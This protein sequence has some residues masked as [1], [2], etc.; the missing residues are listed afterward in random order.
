MSEALLNTAEAARFLRVSQAS[1]RRWSDAGLLPARRVGPRRERRFTKADL[2]TFM[3]PAAQAIARPRDS[4]QTEV[5]VGGTRVPVHSHVATFYSSDDG[6]LRLTIPFIREGLRLGQPCFL[7]AAGD[8]LGG[9]MHALREDE[10]IDVDAASRDGMFVT[11]DGPGDSV[12]AALAFWE[13][14]MSHALASGPTL[15]RVVGEMISE[16]G[17]FTSDAEMIRYEVA[18]NGIAKRFPTVT[19]C[20]YDARSF[21]G[22]VLFHALRAHPDLYHLGIASFLN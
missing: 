5:S 19:L 18:F 11:A 4:I 15:M 6:R 1:I 16:R 14:S 10:G 8:V 21:S 17:V 20:Q 13:R 7:A 9:Y 3:T 12:E 2:T 22:E